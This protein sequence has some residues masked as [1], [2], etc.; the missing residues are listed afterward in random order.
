MKKI[1]DPKKKVFSICTF[2]AGIVAVIGGALSMLTALSFVN[3][4]KMDFM[5]PHGYDE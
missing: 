1:K 4:T 3:R 2:F 5:N